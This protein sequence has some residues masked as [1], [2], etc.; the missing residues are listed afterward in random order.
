[1]PRAGRTILLLCKLMLPISLGVGM[2]RWSGALEAIGKTLAPVMAV[3]HLPG[4]AAVPLVTGLLA[5]IYALLGA[6]AMIPLDPMAVT[7]LGAMA[8]VAHN[9]II[10]TAVQDRT[11]TPW[12]WI[13]LVRLG[14][15]LLVGILV[16]WS[17]Q[18][19]QSHGLPALWLRVVPSTANTAVP[20]SG[21][22]GQFLA[23]WTWEAFRLM[24]KIILVVSAMM[25]GTE[26]IRSRGHLERLEQG[27]RPLL[28]ILGL[29]RTV[30]FPWLMAQILGVTFGGGL[31]IE[32]MKIRAI[33]E[34]D[35][36]AL[37]TSIGISH[38]VFEDTILLA[39][40]GASMFWIIVPRIVV[41]I[42]LVRLIRPLRWGLRRRPA[43]AGTP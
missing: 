14:A 30:A 4:E 42:V 39:A 37:Q 21:G 33:E 18:A 9:L 8:L 7:V 22:L 24:A 34:K 13:L 10:E 11:G 16:S 17:L 5:G 41:A 1:M 26:W 6:M 3:V 20:A 19:L 12:W 40:V 38:S 43:T 32:E 2:L 36:R 29:S 15:S 35:V 27:V 25:I 31:L 28:Y 23:G